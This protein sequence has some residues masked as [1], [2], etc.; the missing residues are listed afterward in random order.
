MPPEALPAKASEIVPVGAI[1]SRC[2]LRMPCAADLG[3]DLVRQARGA[4]RL[5]QE[6]VG[7]EQR[8]GA[9]LARILDRRGI[10]RVAHRARDVGRQCARLL[11]VVA[12]AQH[13]QRVAEPGEAEPDAALVRRF[14]R[15]LGQRPQRGVEHVVERADRDRE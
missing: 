14:L 10:G 6:L 8:E 13:R 1:D 15:L 2:E 5:R 3:L 9:F 12:Q 7:V 4:V 11:A